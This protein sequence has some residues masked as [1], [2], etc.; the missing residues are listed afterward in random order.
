M[1]KFTVPQFIDTEDRILGPITVRQFVL[2]MVG[3]LMLFL[4]YRLILNLTYF[5]IWTIFW[6]VSIGVTA[7]MRINGKPFHFFLLNMIETIRRPNTRVWDKHL[8]HSQIKQ[9][10][11]QKIDNEKKEIIPVKKKV[12][13]STISELSLIADTGGVYE[14]ERD[15]LRYR[16]RIANEEEKRKNKIKLLNQVK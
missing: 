14:G 6:L 15:W 1:K 11:F 5:I 13:R 9:L 16:Q 4:G 12:R 7:F 10:A 2:L 3:A 8:T